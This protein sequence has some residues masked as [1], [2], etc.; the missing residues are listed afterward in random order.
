MDDL[1][2]RCDEGAHQTTIV[3]LD[4]RRCFLGSLHS[5]TSRPVLDELASRSAVPVA[6]QNIST[7]CAHLAGIHMDIPAKRPRLAGSEPACARR[8]VDFEELTGCTFTSC[9]VFERERDLKSV[10]M[11]SMPPPVSLSMPFGSIPASEEAGCAAQL[12][13]GI[14]PLQEAL[15]VRHVDPDVGLGVFAVASIVGGSALLEYT[16]VVRV[17]VPRD[18]LADDDYAFALPVCDNVVISARSMGNMARLLNHDES[19]N[20]QLRTVHHEGLLHVV[21]YTLR[22]VSAGEQLLVHYGRSYWE[23][24]ARRKEQRVDLARRC[25]E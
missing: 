14:W 8:H 22:D 16:G 2:P 15:E 11:W 12:T 3:A 5:G 20:A 10:D 17:D 18:E 9:L 21:A 24:N 4:T 25:D 13:T 1:L 7:M 19:P 23:M 6:E